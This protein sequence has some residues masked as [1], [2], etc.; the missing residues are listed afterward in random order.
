MIN[1][2]KSNIWVEDY[3][4]QALV[5]GMRWTKFCYGYRWL[6]SAK[7]LTSFFQKEKKKQLKIS[8]NIFRKVIHLKD[9]AS[10]I[11]C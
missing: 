8:K 9:M 1:V 11:I 10:P 2:P 5:F 6:P 3:W 7:T 4:P